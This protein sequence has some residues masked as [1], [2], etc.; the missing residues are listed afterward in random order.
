MV[1]GAGGG[2]GGT[3]AGAGAGATTVGVAV[4][5]RDLTKSGALCAANSVNIPQRNPTNSKPQP[6]PIFFN[7][8]F[9]G[10]AAGGTGGGSGAG[11]T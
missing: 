2:A 3:V 8:V 7:G 10:A 6:I 11:G 1:T 9:L 5:V 4:P